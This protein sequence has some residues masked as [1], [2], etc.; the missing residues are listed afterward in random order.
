M[1]RDDI[2][3]MAREAGFEIGSV[4]NAIYA[5]T[6]CEM[7]LTRFA[8]LVAAAE[9]GA[10]ERVCG[11]LA[12]NTENSEQYRMAANWCRERIRARSNA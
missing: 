1:T 10:C 5:P 8:E 2:I 9:R 6:S 7:E 11:E 12:N 4:T 3:R